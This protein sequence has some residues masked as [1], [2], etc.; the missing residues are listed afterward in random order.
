[1]NTFSA[2]LRSPALAASTATP[3]SLMTFKLPFSAAIGGQADDFETGLDG[4]QG[5]GRRILQGGLYRRRARGFLFI[6]PAR[7]PIGPHHGIERRDIFLDRAGQLGAQRLGLGVDGF[8]L[9]PD[10]LVVFLADGEIGHHGD[11]RRADGA[12]HRRRA[13]AAGRRTFAG[14]I[15]EKSPRWSCFW[16]L[17]V[18]VLKNQARAL[19]CA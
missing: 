10:G 7:Q 1:M 16:S 4:A 9:I 5:R 8:K 3:A 12:G 14:E 19:A 2:A 18:S 11:E 13:A 15:V 17:A 6:R